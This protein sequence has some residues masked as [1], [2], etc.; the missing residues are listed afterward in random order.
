MREGR[1]P[2]AVAQWMHFH[3][4]PVLKFAQLQGARTAR[5]PQVPMVAP[6]APGQHTLAS[7]DQTAPVALVK[8]LPGCELEPE[9]EHARHPKA[10]STLPAACENEP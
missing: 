4:D 6:P 7:N 5:H 1:C 10:T 2:A 9:F 3:P 8:D